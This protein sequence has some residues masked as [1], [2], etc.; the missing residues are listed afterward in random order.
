MIN[1]NIKFSY[2]WADVN[3]ESFIRDSVEELLALGV[4]TSLLAVTIV[5]AASTLLELSIT[6]THD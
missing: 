1:S 5:V 3:L 4:S 2:F 6:E